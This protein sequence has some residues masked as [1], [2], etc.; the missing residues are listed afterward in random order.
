MFS[1]FN[2]SLLFKVHVF[3]VS[4][5]DEKHIEMYHLSLTHRLQSSYLSCQGN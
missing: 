2:L 5:K 1:C 3:L 4:I